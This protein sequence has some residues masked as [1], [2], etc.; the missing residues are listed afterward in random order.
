M[1]RRVS[2]NFLARTQQPLLPRMGVY[3]NRRWFSAPQGG[4]KLEDDKV[5]GA[6]VPPKGSNA[7]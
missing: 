4:P 1:I 3:M 6:G 7:S 5:S 2:R